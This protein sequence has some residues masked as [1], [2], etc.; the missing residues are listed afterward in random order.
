MTG[1][2]ALPGE[3][4]AAL[5]AQLQDPQFPAAL[6]EQL[7]EPFRELMVSV[8]AL[9]A[10]ARPPTAAVRSLL[11]RASFP[12]TEIAVAIASKPGPGDDRFR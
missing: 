9:D 12:A 3:S 6:A 10:A 7:P 4:L 1:R 11:E 5:V 2:R 8:L